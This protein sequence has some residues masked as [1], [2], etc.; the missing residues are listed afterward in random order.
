MIRALLLSVAAVALPL[1]AHAQATHEHDEAAP[2]TSSD[3]HAG[4]SA[5]P[6]T[7]AHEGHAAPGT[8]ASAASMPAESDAHAGHDMAPAAEH[9][10]HAPA[11]P[12]SSALPMEH[13]GHG[14]VAT[15]AEGQQTAA[16]LPVGLE[17]PP[18]AV[19]NHAADAFHDPLAM[20][21]ARGV[22]EREHGGE[23]IWKFM[24]DEAEYRAGSGPDGYAW[25]AE[26]W[27]GGDVNR[28]VVTTEGDGAQDLETGEV[29]ALYSRAIGPYTNARVGVR[30][31][32][33][34]RSVTYASMSID[35]LAPYWFEVEASAFL[36]DDG[37]VLARLEGSYDVQ[38]TQRLVVQPRAELLFSAQDSV[39]DQIGAGLSSAE[40]GL[41]LRYEIRREFAPYI[42]VQYERAFGDTADFVRAAGGDAA[43][44]TVVAGV[45]WW[46]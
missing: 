10:G 9:E 36:S 4:H 19:E 31:D 24:I 45:R 41:R 20:D 29:Q 21:R 32:I 39:R 23:P 13:A 7:D 43:H 2:V 3:E 30:Q 35:T 42:G 17:P 12:A 14:A 6:A 25:D 40:V 11:P 16:D 22:L 34:P 8:P 37:D 26:L 1:S 18:A 44:T 33:E 5:A 15:A 46:F 28:F 27:Y 38:L